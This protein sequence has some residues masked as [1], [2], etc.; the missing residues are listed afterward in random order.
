MYSNLAFMLPRTRYDLRT[1]LLVL[2]C[3]SAAAALALTLMP[4]DME[5]YWLA[6][7]GEWT[8]AHGRILESLQGSW[9]PSRPWVDQEWLVAI[10]TAWTRAHGLYVLMQLLFAASL[11]VGICFVALETIRT[12]THPLVACAQVAVTGIGAVFFAQDRAQTL[13]WMLLPVAIVAWRRAPWANVPLLALWAN[14]HGSFPVAVL[15]MLL[16]LDR[17][18]VAPMIAATLATL[19]NPLGW[20]LWAFTFVLARDAKLAGYVNEWTPAFVSLAGVLVTLAA[21]APLWLRLFAG[22]RLRKPVRYGDLIFVAASAIGTIIAVRYSML[23]FLTTATALGDAF[24]T[25]ARPLPVAT[26]AAAI[27]FAV[28]IVA[29]AAEN[30]IGVPVVA[31]PW[32]GGLERGVDFGACAPLVRDRRV[33]SDALEVG[34][35]IELAGG[36]ANVDGRIDAFPR[37]AL[38]ESSAVL[39]D[40][41]DAERIADR[42]GAQM[43]AIK[44]AFQP[45][46]RHWRFAAHCYNVRIYTRES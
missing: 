41:P 13:V 32:F 10:A 38:V 36:T 44:G 30:F 20:H 39:A 25:R 2:V 6:S 19:A 23:L 22:V 28:F 14:L 12:R 3:V 17:R 21:L 35:L 9:Y 1:P 15:W 34:N 43:L 24:R 33:F 46:P 18:R 42:S 31:D 27:V 29:R 5:R 7:A 8:L 4:G 11:I 37:Q 16:H 40:R 45:S 26:V